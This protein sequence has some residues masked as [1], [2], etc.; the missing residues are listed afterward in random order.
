ME[1]TVVL[2]ATL[3]LTFIAISGFGAVGFYQLSK[4]F[5]KQKKL[6]ALIGYGV[7]ITIAFF[8]MPPNPDEVTAPMELVNGFRIM[9]VITASIFW[10]SLGIIL[11]VLWEKVRPETTVTSKTK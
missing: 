7:F 6:I 1:V 5:E 2:R 11:G 3:F 10:I 9:S 8:V 4:K